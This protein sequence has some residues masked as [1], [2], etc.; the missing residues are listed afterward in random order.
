[1]ISSINHK[2]KKPGGGRDIA[3]TK[4]M[5]QQEPLGHTLQSLLYFMQS[6]KVTG[7]YNSQKSMKSNE[8]QG[9]LQLTKTEL[10]ISKHHLH[11]KA[12]PHVR[13]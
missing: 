2:E 11:A 6:L 8:I 4:T 12:F 5:A 1:M 9:E 3:H 7:A 10:S 13:K